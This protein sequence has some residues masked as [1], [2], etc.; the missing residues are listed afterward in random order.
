MVLILIQNVKLEVI[1]FQFPK[2]HLTLSSAVEKSAVNLVFVSMKGICLSP[3]PPT[4]PV[5]FK[6]FSLDLAFCKFTML[7]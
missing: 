2:E 5:A 3:Q 6:I 4:T 1:S 7:C